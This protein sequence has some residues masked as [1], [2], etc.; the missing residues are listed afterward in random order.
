MPSARN[1]PY[2]MS[3]FEDVGHKLFHILASVKLNH[4]HLQ[5]LAFLKGVPRCSVSQ[6]LKVEHI[7][8]NK[9][10]VAGLNEKNRVLQRRVR[11][12]NKNALPYLVSL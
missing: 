2:A 9:Y 7:L 8:D 4:I 10:V 1:A 12:L 11:K 6:A 3:P 5:R